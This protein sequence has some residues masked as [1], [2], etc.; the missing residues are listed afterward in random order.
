MIRLTDSKRSSDCSRRFIPLV[1]S[2][3][4]A[5]LVAACANDTTPPGK[6]VSQTA[7]TRG[8]VI[9]TPPTVAPDKISYAFEPFTGAPGNIADELSGY[10]GNEAH[11][12]G[13]TLVR[14]IGAPATY[15]IN[16]YLSAT[17]DSSS[18]TLFYVFDVVDN[19]G[20]RVHRIVGQESAPGSAGDP[21]S[22]IDSETLR[23]TAQ[24]AIA[25]LRAWAYR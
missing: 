10:L 2:L 22:G 1:F 3:S 18:I 21:W 12:Q 5:L 13:L 20:N 16:G 15:R 23:R 14:R 8:A 11:A 6:I 24:R 9:S 17:G 25:S 19:A 4:S 7:A